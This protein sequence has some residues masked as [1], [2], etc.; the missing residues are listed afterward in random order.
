MVRSVGRLAMAAGGGVGVALVVLTILTVPSAATRSVTDAVQVSSLYNPGF[1]GGMGK[2]QVYWTP[3]GGPFF[4]GKDPDDPRRDNIRPPE[5]WTAWWRDGFDCEA[6][7]T[8]TGQPEMVVIDATDPKRVDSGAQALKAFTFFRCHDMGILQ[9]TSVVSGVTYHVEAMAHAWYTSCS[10]KPYEPPH[11]GDCKPWYGVHDYLSVGIDP[12]GGIDPLGP[13]V[14][15]GQETEIYGVYDDAITVTARAEAVTITVFLRSHADTPLRHDDTYWDSVI[16]SADPTLQLVPTKVGMLAIEGGADPQ[17]RSIQINTSGSAFGWTATLNPAVSWLT[18]SPL[19][20]TA[21]AVFTATADISGLAIDTYMTTIIVDSGDP[22]ED[23]PQTIPLTL[24]VTDEI[25]RA[26][27][28]RLS[29][30]Y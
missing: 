18:I 21:S 4:P 26:F 12:K 14:V 19:S 3:D 15:W 22:V 30:G 16:L 29:W 24:A 20:G 5:G 11:D 6:F 27:L 7:P 9:T 13:D 10:S 17:P 28:P 23:I 1:E 25:H 2:S 8:K